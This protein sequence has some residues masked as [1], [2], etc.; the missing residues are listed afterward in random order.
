MA[1]DSLDL[2][3]INDAFELRGSSLQTLRMSE[4]L[5]GQG[6]S[7]RI[8]CSDAS[9][10]N[11]D[12]RVKYGLQVYPQIKYQLLR[13]IVLEFIA[14]DLKH[15]IPDLIHIQT[16][17]MHGFGRK[18]ARKLKRPYVL[19]FHDYLKP[20]EMIPLDKK[21]CMM[22][23]AISDSIKEHLVHQLKVPDNFVQVIPSGVRIQ[24][25]PS[26]EFDDNDPEQITVVGTA[27]PL[28]IS[29]GLKFFLE[30]ASKVII[31][32]KRVQFLIAGAGPEEKNLRKQVRELKIVSN[33]TFVPPEYELENTIEALN[34]FCLPSL[35]QGL[36]TIMLE[37]MANGKPVIATRVGGV[38][39]VIQHGQTG[40]LVPPSHS[41]E[42]SQAM[43]SLINNPGLR[44]QLAQ[45]G[46]EF[47]SKDY[48]LSHMIDLMSTVYRQCL[49]RFLLNRIQEVS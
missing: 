48:Q 1:K 49:Q 41:D 16:H 7:V 9:Q 18:L 13:S 8:L 38:N 5:P 36:G 33:V 26:V 28:E 14:S 43:L 21:Y 22:L 2:L 39:S 4:E 25:K 3:I 42:L 24:T 27:G 11:P 45:A 35:Q 23:I 44:R 29:K 31:K 6:I 30:A 10:I 12:H 47:V 20:R 32:N 46:Q 17:R 37:A 15:S 34:I 40:L 19:S